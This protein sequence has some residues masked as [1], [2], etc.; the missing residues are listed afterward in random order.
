MFASHSPYMRSRATLHLRFTFTASRCDASLPL[1][2]LLGTGTRTIFFRTGKSVSPVLGQDVWSPI[3]SFSYAAVMRCAK[4]VGAHVTACLIDMLKLSTFRT[5]R[6]FQFSRR[7]L[8]ASSEAYASGS[9]TALRRVS[10]QIEGALDTF[11]LC[12][13]RSSRWPRSHRRGPRSLRPRGRTRWTASLRETQRR[14]AM[15]RC[16]TCV[17]NTTWTT[18]RRFRS[19]R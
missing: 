15:P 12:L 10:Y 7:P 5:L 2:L 4:F 14:E 16:S 8:P 6:I 19:G 11:P 3:L 1:S 17:T 13:R 18:C 9:S